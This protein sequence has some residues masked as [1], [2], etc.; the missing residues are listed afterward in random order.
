M[1]KPLPEIGR[2]LPDIDP[3]TFRLVDLSVTSPLLYGGNWTDNDN[4]WKLLA[5]ISRE[6][7]RASTRYGEY[8][9]SKGSTDPQQEPESFALH[10][11]ACIPARITAVAP[12]PG[13]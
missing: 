5:H 8:R 10:I 4:D 7:G 12:L 11:D 3:E 13:R 6:T 2:L 1:T 9:L